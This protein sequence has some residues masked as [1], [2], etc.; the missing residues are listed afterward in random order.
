MKGKFNQTHVAGDKVNAF[1]AANK[2]GVLRKRIKNRRKAAVSPH[3]STSVVPGSMRGRRPARS[4]TRVGGTARGRPFVRTS[5]RGRRYLV[6][7]KGR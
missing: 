3:A 4:S 7:P 1:N 5:P 2:H 6:R